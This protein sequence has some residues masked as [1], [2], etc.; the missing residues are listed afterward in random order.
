MVISDSAGAHSE[1][2]ANGPVGGW[3]KIGNAF[4]DRRRRRVPACSTAFLWFPKLTLDGEHMNRYKYRTAGKKVQ[5]PRLVC[6][7]CDDL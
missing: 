3:G 6:P 4:W 7:D 5:I 1:P 2:G